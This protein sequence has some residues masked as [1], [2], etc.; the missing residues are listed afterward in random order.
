MQIKMMYAICN[1][2]GIEYKAFLQPVLY[3]KKN[4]NDSDIDVA[5]LEGFM[6]DISN[7]SLVAVE[8][9]E[10][11]IMLQ[12]NAVYFRK[13]AES[14]TE[15]WFYDLSDLFDNESRIYMD[16]CHVYE[17]GNKIIAKKIFEIIKYDIKNL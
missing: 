14:I 6:L 5:I 9:T 7:K 3:N 11:C 13:M 15:P 12:K 16:Y 10:K 2:L 1:T 8:A 17:K 4:I